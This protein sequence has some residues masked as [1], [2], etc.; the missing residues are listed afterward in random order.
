VVENGSVGMSEL[1]AMQQLAQAVWTADP[2]MMNT[3]ASVGELAWSW[4]AGRRLHATEW[5]HRLWFDGDLIAAWGWFSAPEMIRVADDRWELSP[6]SL[7]WQV[8]PDHPELLDDVLEWFDHEAGGAHRCVTARAADRGAIERL[9]RH[10]YLH[11]PGAPWSQ[12]NRR[13]L[14]ELEA[15]VLPAGFR[16][17]T[18]VEVD[19]AAAVAVERAA[20]HPSQFTLESLL[21]V[22]ST[23]PYHDDLAVFV[24]APAG[25]LVASALEWYDEINRTAELEPV[26]TDPGYRRLGLGRAV[27][28]FGLHQARASGAT[29]AVV[30]CRGD[31]NYPVPRRLY[32]SIGFGELTRDLVFAK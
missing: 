6:T 29:D 16:L 18:G 5:R 25:M 10:G 28:V 13:P 8:H 22:R 9:G 20:W 21:D 27:S 7:V 1:R 19:P 32:G 30:S 3:G 4:G 12:L 2:A 15:P 26:G 14:R 31:E 11:D 24:Q 23:W 17:R